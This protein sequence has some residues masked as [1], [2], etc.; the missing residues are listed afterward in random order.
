MATFLT[1][2]ISS[3][4]GYFTALYL[5]KRSEKKRKEQRRINKKYHL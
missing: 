5:I 2:A 4:I 1:V 3:M